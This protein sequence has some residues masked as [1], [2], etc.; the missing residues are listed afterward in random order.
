MGRRDTRRFGSSF[1]LAR[2]TPPYHIFRNPGP[3]PN[4]LLA[5]KAHLQMNRRRPLPA[6]SAIAGHPRYT[7]PSPPKNVVQPPFGTTQRILLGRHHEFSEMRVPNLECNEQPVYMVGVNRRIPVARTASSR[8][9]SIS[10]ATGEKHTWPVPA[11]TIRDGLIFCGIE[12]PEGIAV[13]TKRGI[14]APKVTVHTST[15]GDIVLQPHPM[16]KRVMTLPDSIIPAESTTSLSAADDGVA[17]EDSPLRRPSEADSQLRCP[18]EGFASDTPG[19]SRSNSVPQAK[20]AST[21]SLSDGAAKVSSSEADSQLGCPPTEATTAKAEAETEDE[22]EAE[23]TTSDDDDD[24]TDED[25]K[26]LYAASSDEDGEDAV[27]VETRIAKVAA[28]SGESSVAAGIYQRAPYTRPY[29]YIDL[30]ESGL[31]A[32][33]HSIAPREDGRPMRVSA[34]GSHATAA[35]DSPQKVTTDFNFE[36]NH[37]P[38]NPAL[39]SDSRQRSSL[40]LLTKNLPFLNGAPLLLTKDIVGFSVEVTSRHDRSE[41]IEIGDF[42][43]C[44]AS[45]WVMTGGSEASE[46]RWVVASQLKPVAPSQPAQEFVVPAHMLIDS[47]MPMDVASGGAVVG[48]G[49]IDA[50]VPTFLRNSHVPVDARTA[51]RQLNVARMMGTS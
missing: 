41:H 13:D 16:M 29:E 27:L 47:I 23:Q 5:L 31:N 35:D 28:R 34:T 38:T 26:Y 14:A 10:F 33:L 7:P 22:A 51:N 43:L 32:R 3:V 6:A 36:Q 2:P 21:T 44:M 49:G 45:F 8:T 12:M 9:L 4:N 17:A 18:A 20:E 46:P 39:S 40:A 15:H 19:S 48:G 11:E 50:T 42:L 30:S 37:S 1:V 24:D 25:N